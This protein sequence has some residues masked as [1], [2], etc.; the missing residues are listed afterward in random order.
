MRLVCVF[1]LLFSSAAQ[2]VV[3]GVPPAEDDRRFDAVGAWSRASWLGLGNNPIQQHNWFGG[4][5]LLRANLVATVKHISEDVDAP[6][7]TYAVR[8]RRRIDG[9]LGTICT[10]S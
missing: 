3:G 1:M 4:A 5:V 6:A 8:F 7:G 9:G 10:K 2:A